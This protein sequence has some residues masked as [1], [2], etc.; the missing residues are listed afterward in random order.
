[1]ENKQSVK[2]EISTEGN[3]YN[4]FLNEISIPYITEELR[5]SWTGDGALNL[6][7]SLSKSMKSIFFGSFFHVVEDNEKPMVTFAD[8]PETGIGFSVYNSVWFVQV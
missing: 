1:M 7:E 6:K 4:T 3:K 8:N 5:Q 2:L